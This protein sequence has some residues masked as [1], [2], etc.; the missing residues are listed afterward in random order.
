MLRA[1]I[2]KVHTDDLARIGGFTPNVD[3]TVAANV[4]S[5]IAKNT[6]DT[7]NNTK[8]GGGGGIP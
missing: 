7:A 8:I 5:E 2:E 4:L 3:S 1:A 6:R